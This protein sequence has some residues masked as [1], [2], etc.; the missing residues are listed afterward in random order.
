MPRPGPR[1]QYIGAR[2]SEQQIVAID[3]AA[4]REGVDRSEII[5]RAVD[6]YVRE[7]EW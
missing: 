4:A 1:R 6:L 7:H 2:M 5:R 3:R